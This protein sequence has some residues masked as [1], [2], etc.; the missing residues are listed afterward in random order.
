MYS[1]TTDGRHAQDLDGN[2]EGSSH[3]FAGMAGP[4]Q[5]VQS[6]KYWSVMFALQAFSGIHVGI[7]TVLTYLAALQGQLTED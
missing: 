4:L 3:I 7:D 1:T 5:T 2:F 6:V